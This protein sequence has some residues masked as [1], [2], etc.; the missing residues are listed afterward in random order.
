[1][2]PR[3]NHSN[4][5]QLEGLGLSEA[6]LLDI[7]NAPSSYDLKLRAPIFD[8]LHPKLIEAKIKYLNNPEQE[9]VQIEIPGW[10]IYPLSDAEQIPHAYKV[11]GQPFEIAKILR[12][13]IQEA[14]ID[15]APLGAV[16]LSRKSQDVL[17]TSGIHQHL[18]P[19]WM[20]YVLSPELWGPQGK[21]TRFHERLHKLFEEHHLL[22]GQDLPGQY[23]LTLAANKLAD[24]GFDGSIVNNSS[25][26]T[27]SWTF[28]LTALQHLEKVVSQEF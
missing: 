18:I 24:F 11:Y 10:F 3:I 6:I 7:K 13:D 26:L 20:N 2:T 8:L 16:L 27:L 19:V 5:E 21:W 15:F 4:L 25:V 23:P 9:P 22:N 14:V 12:D 17:I 28:P 1:M